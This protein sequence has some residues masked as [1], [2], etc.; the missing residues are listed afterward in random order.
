MRSLEDLRKDLAEKGR[1]L[2]DDDPVITFYYFLEFF[3]KDLR[4]LFA[5]LAV[6]AEVGSDNRLK[7]WNEQAVKLAERSLSVAITKSKQEAEK[8]FSAKAD[9][10]Q[11]SLDKVL[12]RHLHQQKEEKSSLILLLVANILIFSCTSFGWFFFLTR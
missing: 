12:N 4:Q 11:T 10:F 8:L 3:E 9:E 7:E 2:Q 1:L 6:Q 5:S